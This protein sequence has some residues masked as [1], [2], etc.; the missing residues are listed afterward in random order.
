MFWLLIIIAVPRPPYIDK[1][2]AV[3][4]CALTSGCAV[5]VNNKLSAYLVG[6]GKSGV[7]CTVL[8]VC[9]C[10]GRLPS[11]PENHHFPLAL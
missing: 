1:H 7:A 8:P 11:S 4:N 6:Q 2:L 5:W 9:T 3:L 10:L